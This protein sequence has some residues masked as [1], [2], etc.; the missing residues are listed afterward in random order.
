VQD[1]FRSI[2]RLLGEFDDLSDDIKFSFLSEEEQ[3]KIQKA[4]KALLE[5]GKIAEETAKKQKLLETTKKGNVKDKSA[6]DK[7]TKKVSGLTDEKTVKQAKLSGAKTK[8]DA[9]K[10]LEN[11]NPKDIAKYEAEVSKLTAELEVLERNLK[12]AN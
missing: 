9:A 6:L 7:A 4:S 12:E 11:G 1:S 8:L 2:I 10:S 5:Y 3:R